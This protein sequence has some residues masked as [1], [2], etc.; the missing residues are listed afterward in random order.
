MPQAQFP[1]I[2]AGANAVASLLQSFAGLEA[3]KAA[4]TSR[5]GTVTALAADPDLTVPLAANDTYSFD[6]DLLYEGG[7][8][9]AAD[10][11]VGWTVPAGTTMRY[12]V[13]NTSTT[14]TCTPGGSTEAT[15]TVSGTNGAANLRGIH[16]GGTV[17]AGGTA[18]ALTLTWA[19][20]TSNATATILHLG[21]RMVLRRKA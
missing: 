1:A 16:M 6:L 9:G 3:W 7:T 19:T 8:Q 10:L 2:L 12:T 18:G 15:V 11:K 13:V 17:F 14:G 21:S 5:A 4:D 20:N